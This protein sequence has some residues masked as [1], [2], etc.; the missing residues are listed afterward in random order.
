MKD[1]NLTPELVAKARGMKTEEELLQLAK[2]NDIDLTEEQVKEYFTKLNP[3]SGELADE[4]L[5]NVSGGG[6]SDPMLTPI[7][8]CPWCRSKNIKFLYSKFGRN[9]RCRDCSKT[10]HESDYFGLFESRDV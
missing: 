9:Y 6:C 3:K 2:E 1:V 8:F 7:L 5:D 10:F 4:E